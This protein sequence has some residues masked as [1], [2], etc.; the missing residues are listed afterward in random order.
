MWPLSRTNAYTINKGTRAVLTWSRLRCVE[1]GGKNDGI[2]AAGSEAVIESRNDERTSEYLEHVPVLLKESI[3][4]LV[5]NPDGRY[6]DMTL[7][8]GG[9]AEEILKRLS[10]KGSLVGLDRD[11]EA[12]YHTVK[13]LQAYVDAKK[14]HPVIGTFSNVSRI[15]ESQGLPLEGYSG[16][17]ADLGISTHQLECAR[18]GFAYNTDG[19]LDMRMSNPLH[20]PLH[21]DCPID[22]L[23]SLE[24]SNTAFKVINQGREY[25]IARIIKE[26]GEEGRAAL[27]AKRIVEKRKHMGGIS[28]TQQ[29]RDV[30]LS[31]VHANR[32]TAMKTLSRVFQ[33]FRIYVNDELA[34][35]QRLLDE[36]PQM[37]H[38]KHGRLVVISYHSLE[39][40]MVKR[41]FSAL[42]S[43]SESSPNLTV[44]RVVTKK[45]LTS[46]DMENRV[47]Q[48]ARSAKLR[49]LERCKYKPAE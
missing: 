23:Q 28:T 37:L 40:R 4:M 36:V 44:F 12:V 26:Y 43:V 46:T 8:Y 17:I 5:T 19:P 49:C 11:P 9:H 14:L 16:V 1:G 38:R 34:E 48:K 45:C 15:L 2:S 3:G 18:R 31:C 25:E 20:D 29:L 27:F 22:P 42:Q 21:K 10:P 24:K 47:N 41:A 30:I 39:D 33:A 13:R 7:G 32:K 6:L 35:L